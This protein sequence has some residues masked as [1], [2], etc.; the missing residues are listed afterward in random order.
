MHAVVYFDGARCGI[1]I[2]TMIAKRVRIIL[3]MYAILSCVSSCHRPPEANQLS[4]AANHIA[5]PQKAEPAVLDNPRVTSQTPE[6]APEGMPPSPRLTQLLAQAKNSSLPRPVRLAALDEIASNKGEASSKALAALISLTSSDESEQRIAATASVSARYPAIAAI[7]S[8]GKASVPS[9]CERLVE[10]VSNRGD[11]T[12]IRLICMTALTL[13]APE[14]LKAEVIS[15]TKNKPE[16][17]AASDEA[18][19]LI[20]SFARRFP[21]ATK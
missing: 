10:L 5:Q 14:T 11:R 3:H 4:G 7:K 8:R 6:F 18:I 16:T 1:P 19:M 12:E 2:N 17:T 15:L 9:L 21:A 13:D 20:D